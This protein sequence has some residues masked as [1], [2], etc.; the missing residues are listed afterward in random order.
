MPSRSGFDDLAFESLWSDVARFITREA[1]V[2]EAPRHHRNVGVERTQLE[3]TH[4]RR[5]G[6]PARGG[7]TANEQAREVLEELPAPIEPSRVIERAEGE[8]ASRAP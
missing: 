3:L 6:P 1:T 2:V 5:G 8:A 7:V 4:P